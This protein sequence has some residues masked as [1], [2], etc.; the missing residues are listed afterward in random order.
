MTE[1]LAAVVSPGLSTIQDGGRRGHAA[2]GVPASGALHRERYLLATGLVTGRIDDRVPALELLGGEL[3]LEFARAGVFGVVGPVHMTLDDQPTAAGSTMAASA[4]SQLRVRWAGPGPAYVAL[5]GWQA[6]AV[7]GSVA[8][9][10]FSRLGGDVLQV[11]SMLV[12]RSV[13]A[14][15]LVG[16]FH[17]PLPDEHGPLRI[18]TT[19]RPETVAFAARSWQVAHA[20]RS[21]V[22]LVPQGLPGSGSVASGPTLPG[23]IQLTPSGE[24]IILGPDGGIT[25]GYPVL[26]VVAAVDRDRVSMVAPGDELSFRMVDVDAAARLRHERRARLRR[27]LAHVRQLT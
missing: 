18:V 15:Q 1:L 14:G 25:G 26:G 16:G 6:P 5:V 4:G 13:D 19:G 22:R 7:L 11:G 9:D 8:T 3:V 23:A 21:G 24:P 10:T 27:S 20:S 12:G 2:V 17:R